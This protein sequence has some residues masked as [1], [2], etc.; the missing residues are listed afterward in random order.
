MTPIYTD[1]IHMDLKAVC[2]GKNKNLLS[3]QSVI[4]LENINVK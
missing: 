3:K 1:M 2:E 4:D